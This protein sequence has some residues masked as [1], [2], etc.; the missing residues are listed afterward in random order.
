MPTWPIRSMNARSQ[1][2]MKQTR[3]RGKAQTRQTKGRHDRR[4][5]REGDQS[6]SLDDRREGVAR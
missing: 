2:G 6:T 5:D 4:R 1:A 3:E